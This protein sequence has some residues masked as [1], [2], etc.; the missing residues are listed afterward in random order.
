MDLIPKNMVSLHLIDENFLFAG[1]IN[2]KYS[3]KNSYEV[4]CY[5]SADKFISDTKTKPL[6]IKGTHIVILAVHL[7]TPDSKITNDLIEL[8]NSLFKGIYIIRIC[9]EK[10]LVN[11]PATRI[12]NVIKVVNNENALMRIDN[13]VKWVLAKTNLDQMKRKYKLA[14]YILIISLLIS[15]AIFSFFLLPGIK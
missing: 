9:H 4:I 10:E 15:A 5:P 1:E 14:I 11:D 7:G 2:E 3:W 8:L 6:L 13:A 12:G